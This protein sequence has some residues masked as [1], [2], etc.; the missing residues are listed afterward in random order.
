VIW[1]ALNGIYLIAEIQWQGL[2]NKLKEGRSGLAKF[3]VN[4][5]LILFTFSLT[6]LAWIFFRANSINDAFYVV[7]H[8]FD[9]FSA[10]PAN[11]MSPQFLKFNVLLSKDKW[12]FIFALGGIAFLLFT[13]YL[14]RGRSGR[15]LLNQQNIV[16]RWAFYL[17]II[18]AILFL[19]AFNESQQFIYFQF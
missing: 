17:T 2:V 13:H 7:S 19:G 16:I 15:T 8:L 11:L 12:H 10:L 6:C 1:G 18:W 5:I 9:G 14:Q 3:G 4:V